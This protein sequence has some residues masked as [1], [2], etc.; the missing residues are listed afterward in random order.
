MIE[1]M[2]Q[3]W[4][5]SSQKIPNNHIGTCHI[6]LQTTKSIYFYMVSK[7]KAFPLEGIQH[8]LD[9][10]SQQIITATIEKI[11]CMVYSYI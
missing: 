8:L 4:N 10:A 3:M 1:R 2:P 9:N 5:A 11:S 6:L 7:I